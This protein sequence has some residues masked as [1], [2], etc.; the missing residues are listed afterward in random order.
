MG[1]RYHYLYRVSFPTRGCFYYGVH[2]TDDMNDGYRGSPHTHR[3]KWENHDWYI[4]PVEFFDTREELLLVEQR[5]NK[6]TMNNPLSLNENCGT[7]FSLETCSKGGRIGGRTVVENGELERVRKGC[8]TPEQRRK[9]SEHIQEYNSQRD[10]EWWRQQ[11]IKG[12][13]VTSEKIRR[14]IR[15]THIDTGETHEF[16]SV[17]E[18]CITLPLHSSNIYNIINGKRSNPHKGWIIDLLDPE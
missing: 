13:L 14:P 17:K 12:G 7:G 16:K 2:S 18:C 9:V 3:G 10:P 11:S 6:H 4:E 8:H 5:I 15:V 1:K